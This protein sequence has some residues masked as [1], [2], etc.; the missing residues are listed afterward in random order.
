MYPYNGYIMEME[1]K[2]SL[3][4]LFLSTT[5][6]SLWSFPLLS[7]GYKVQSQLCYEFFPFPIG[8]FRIPVVFEGPRHSETSCMPSS[9][10]ATAGTLIASICIPRIE[11]LH[12]FHT[13]L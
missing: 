4:S 8:L 5:P 13:Q 3:T 7:D 11:L 10:L 2:L 1:S 12:P 6:F 9:S